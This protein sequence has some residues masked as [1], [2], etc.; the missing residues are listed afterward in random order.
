PPLAGEVRLFG[1]PVGRWR[2]SELARHVAW[3]PQ[4][5]EP[6]EGLTGLE[7]VLMGRAPFTGTWQ[8]SSSGDVA[9]AEAALEALGAGVLA[10]RP[11][12]QLSGGEQRLLLLA[13]ALV[14]EP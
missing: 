14:Q 11:C 10:S 1:T 6:M 5:F 3:V 8:L 9:R 12:E 2:A 7:L 4:R 13:R